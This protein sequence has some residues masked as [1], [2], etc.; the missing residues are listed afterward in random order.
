MITRDCRP[1]GDFYEVPYGPAARGTAAAPPSKSHTHRALCCAALAEGRSL[2]ENPLHSGDTT[3]TRRCLEALGAVIRETESGWMVAGT[4][5]AF[6]V[7]DHPL[8]CGSSGTTLRFLMA[9]CAAVPGKRR[10]C[11][12]KQLERR[13][14][15]D[16]ALVLESLGAKFKWLANKGFAP[17]E[18]EGARW[19]GREAIIPSGVSSQFLSALLLAAPMAS[20]P[21]TFTAQRLVSAP[22]ARLTARVMGRFG[23]WVENS[24]PELWRV[25]PSVY[26]SANERIEPDASAAAFLLAAAAV[27]GGEVRVEG[28]TRN[29][30]QGDAVVLN[31]MEAFGVKVTENGSGAAVSGA[32]ASGATLNMRDCPDLVPP[33]AAVAFA[34]PAP[35]RFRNVV[36][37]RAKESDRLA[38]LAYGIDAL[39]G[40]ARDEGSDFVIVPPKKSVGAVLDPRGDHRM[41]MAFAI[42]GLRAEGTV[43]M[44]KGCVNKSFPNFFETLESLMERTGKAPRGANLS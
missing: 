36:H 18:I 15:A 5:G 44:D 20:A 16:L 38:V 35:S 12:S 3:A 43:V 41:A 4:G 42:M 33:L 28:I 1:C 11:G 17:V 6:G 2:I 7:P 24:R 37:L 21:C 39:G 29:L 23:V 8:D 34:A 25:S 40:Q 10:L 9:M 26:L 27:T 30:A 22:Y 13:P 19:S 31:H 32:P 14:A